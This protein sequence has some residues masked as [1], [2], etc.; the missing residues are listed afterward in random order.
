ERRGVDRGK[1]ERV[2]AEIDEVV[3]ALRD[4][5]QVADPV[6]VRVLERAWV[7]LVDD[8]VLPPHEWPGYVARRRGFSLSAF[9]EA[10]EQS[11]QQAIEPPLVR[12]RE[13]QDEGFL[14]RDVRLDCP[15]DDGAAGPGQPDER[16]AAVA[17]LGR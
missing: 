12:R 10:G 17:G 14:V 4:P 6:A 7:D 5:S 8:R 9:V 15:I 13:P 11:A 2:H 1:P 3:E 16:A